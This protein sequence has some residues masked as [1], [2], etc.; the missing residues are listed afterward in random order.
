MAVMSLAGGGAHEIDD[1]GLF[2]VDLPEDLPSFPRAPPRGHLCRLL[3]WLVSLVIGLVDVPCEAIGLQPHSHAFWTHEG[4]RDG[5]PS[6][7]DL[8]PEWF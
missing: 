4:F 1:L 2:P 7:R 5:K 3:V 6:P 8:A